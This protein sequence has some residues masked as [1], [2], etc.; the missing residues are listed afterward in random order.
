VT[1]FDRL[2][3]NGKQIRKPNNAMECREIDAGFFTAVFARQK[4][5]ES[6]FFFSRD[7]IT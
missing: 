7:V 2:R 5:Y 3:L 4:I 1:D 6:T